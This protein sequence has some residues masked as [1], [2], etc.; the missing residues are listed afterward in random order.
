M[1]A[2]ETRKQKKNSKKKI[3]K[4]GI[5]RF[6]AKIGYLHHGFLVFSSAFQFLQ[7]QPEM[8]NRD[9]AACAI[10]FLAL[11]IR[12]I[13]LARRGLTHATIFFGHPYTHTLIIQLLRRKKTEKKIN[14]TKKTRE[15]EKKLFW[16]Q[17]NKKQYSDPKYKIVFIFFFFFFSFS[18]QRKKE[19]L[20]FD[21]TAEGVGEPTQK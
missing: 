2:L 8:T 14:K 12:N 15:R 20:S 9:I 4:M 18:F 16:S 7:C 5:G 6:Y 11:L 21:V 1:P 19:V 3:E 17:Q 13:S 10:V